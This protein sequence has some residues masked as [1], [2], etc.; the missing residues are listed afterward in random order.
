M[1]ER[2]LV[3]QALERARGNQTLAAKLLRV[4]RDQIRY[5]IKKFG[6]DDSRTTARSDPPTAVRLEA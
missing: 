6:L 4:H 3:V 5:R 2:Q 1:V